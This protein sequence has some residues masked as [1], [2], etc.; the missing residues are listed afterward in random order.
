MSEAKSY[1]MGR[2]VEHDD[3]PQPV[4]GPP[5]KG[6][7][8]DSYSNWLNRAPKPTGRHAAITR[9]L[10]SWSSYKSWADKVRSSWDDD[11]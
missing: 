3:E 6:G 4:A 2:A 1:N 9:S 8:L 5:A 11:K 10:Y 7:T